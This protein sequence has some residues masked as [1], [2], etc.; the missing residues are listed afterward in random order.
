VKPSGE[1]AL[2]KKRFDDHFDKEVGDDP[3]GRNQHGD[4]V[5]LVGRVPSFF[6]L[7]VKQK[8]AALDASQF[9]RLQRHD[10]AA[11][12]LNLFRWQGHGRLSSLISVMDGRA[13]DR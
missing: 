8:L 7:V 2:S 1:C 13:V 6:I 11:L 10:M 3:D 12:A 9:F 5:Y 4:E